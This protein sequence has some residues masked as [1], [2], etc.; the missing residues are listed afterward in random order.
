M[1]MCMCACVCVCVHMCMRV[2]LLAMEAQSRRHTESMYTTAT[3]RQNICLGR[4]GV[5]PLDPL[6]GLPSSVLA[7][8]P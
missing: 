8:V 6:S 4:L 2:C 3:F 1:C 5:N 7:R